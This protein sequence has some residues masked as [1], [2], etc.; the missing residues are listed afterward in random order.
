LIIAIDPEEKDEKH[1]WRMAA[2]AAKRRRIALPCH[3]KIIV[4]DSAIHSDSGF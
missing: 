3:C 2:V 1:K 4:S